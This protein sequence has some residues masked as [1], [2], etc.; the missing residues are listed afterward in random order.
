MIKRMIASTKIS[1]HGNLRVDDKVE[2]K[3][4]L[5]SANINYMSF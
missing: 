1:I 5:F 4:R 3:I 2:D